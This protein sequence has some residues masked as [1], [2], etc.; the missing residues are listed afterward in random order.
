[1]AA[2]CPLLAKLGLSLTKVTDEGVK[3]VAAACPLLAE[4]S[5]HQ[6]NVTD[7]GVKAV[8]AACP[9]AEVYGP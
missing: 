5:L 7:E 4:L 1:M 6:T 8:A 2:A 9:T 3:A